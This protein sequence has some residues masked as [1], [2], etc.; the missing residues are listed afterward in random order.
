IDGSNVLAIIVPGSS[1]RPHFAGPS[2]VRQGSRTIAASESQFANLIASRN[3]KVSE[4]LKWKGKGVT[5]GNIR[6][7]GQAPSGYGPCTLV[8]CN[9]FYVTLDCGTRESFPLD[10]IDLSFD[11]IAKCLMI[12]P[13]PA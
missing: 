6:R 7:G 5:R 10:R 3:E 1:Q 8:D 11:E 2:Y 9:Q 13:K 4:I 12:I